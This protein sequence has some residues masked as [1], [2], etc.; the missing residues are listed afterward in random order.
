MKI[1]RCGSDPLIS[2][3]RAR[4]P[5]AVP[6]AFHVQPR[7]AS[8][9]RAELSGLHAPRCEPRKRRDASEYASVGKMCGLR[10]EKKEVGGHAHGTSSHLHKT[11]GLCWIYCWGGDLQCAAPNYMLNFPRILISLN[12]SE[13]AGAT[14]A[15]S[16]NLRRASAHTHWPTWT[17]QAAHGGSALI[18][19]P[20]PAA[21]PGGL[22][23]C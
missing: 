20:T 8:E 11:A 10:G 15:T 14:E 1:R 7:P 21:E 6:A 22:L 16:R 17:R 2:S 4:S 12:V 3:R 23:I 5:P 18:Q 13:G 9:A 19:G